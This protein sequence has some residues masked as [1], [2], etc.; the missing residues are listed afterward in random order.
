MPEIRLLFTADLHIGRSLHGTSFLADQRHILE[1]IL[2][3]MRTKRV[4][5]LVIGGDLFDRA[6][7]S[8]DAVA[9]ADWFFQECVSTLGVQ[10]VVIA[11]NHD[12]PERLDFAAALLAR[13]GL[14]ITGSFPESPAP[15]RL[16]T[17]GIPVELWPL[18]YA[19]PS[20][21]HQCLDR[22]GAAGHNE[23]PG[24]HQLAWNRLMDWLR[25][26][27]QDRSAFRILVG[28]LFVTGGS[29][30]E[31]ERPLTIGGAQAVRPDSFP[32]FDLGLFGHLHRAQEVAAGF[33]YSGSPLCYS[34]S[35]AGQEKSVLLVTVRSPSQPAKKETALP[36][37][38]DLFA[39]LPL[40]TPDPYIQGKAVTQL[41]RIALVPLRPVRRISGM[42]AD[43]LAGSSDDYLFVSLDD[44]MPIPDA[45]ARLQ[46]AYPHLLHVERSLTWEQSETGGDAT[47]RRRQAIEAGDAALVATFI[48]D[49]TGHDPEADWLRLIDEILDEQRRDLVSGESA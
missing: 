32:G 17:G 29:E 18:P 38:P 10:V 13:Q 20:T 6:V 19:E 46:Q 41:D 4:K 40:S 1:S 33:N 14:H 21:V 48:R 44:P 26:Q 43:L 15:L 28:H 34:A 23:D 37:S 24:N 2:E 45:F 7:P 27:W 42:L 49:M 47:E 31:S 3:I 25:L 5:W 39:D 11:G 12:S 35:E 9:L 16:D 30:S 8:A 22:L 36:Q